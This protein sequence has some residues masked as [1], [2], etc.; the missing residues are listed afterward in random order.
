MIYDRLKNASLASGNWQVWKKGEA[1]PEA[2][3]RNSDRIAPIVLLPSQVCALWI[4]LPCV[5]D[6]VYL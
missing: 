1:P 6:K 5:S 3:Y 4:I 2:H